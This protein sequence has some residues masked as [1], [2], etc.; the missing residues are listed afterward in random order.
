MYQLPA[1]ETVGAFIIHTGAVFY[2]FL[3]NRNP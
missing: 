3:E 2:A 1:R